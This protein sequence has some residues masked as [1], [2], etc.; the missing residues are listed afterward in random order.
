MSTRQFEIARMRS[1]AGLTQ[2]EAADAL[3]V[4]KARYGDWERE[5]REIN[6]RDA[7]RLA[8]LFGCS[9]DELAGRKTPNAHAPQL[10]PEAQE[11][12][13]LYDSSN[14]QGRDA[15]MAVARASSGVE[16]E[17]A[18]GQIARTA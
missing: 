3:G 2:Q 17:F 9:L 10:S 6:F 11:L 13:D 12:V 16:R 4:K 5:T 15:I 1:Y 8:D 7:I 14:A 18:D